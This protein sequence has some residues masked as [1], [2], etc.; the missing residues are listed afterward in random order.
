MSL[1]GLLG[2]SVVSHA[3]LIAIASHLEASQKKIAM[4]VV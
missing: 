3:F 4:E 1:F 2:L